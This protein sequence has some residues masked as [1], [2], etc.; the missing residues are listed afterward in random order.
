M[1]INEFLI[2]NRNQNGHRTGK[3]IPIYILH[4]ITNSNLLFDIFECK[5]NKLHF[6]HSYIFKSCFETD[7]KC[8]NKRIKNDM[9]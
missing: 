6:R 3:M 2:N 7:I 8:L 5:F 1:N 4:D 9:F